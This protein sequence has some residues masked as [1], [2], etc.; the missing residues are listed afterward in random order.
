MGNPLSRC[1]SRTWSSLPLP[2]P[3]PLPPQSPLWMIYLDCRQHWPWREVEKPW[4]PCQSPPFTPHTQASHLLWRSWVTHPV[5]TVHRSL[6]SCLLQAQ[7]VSF[8]T[9]HSPGAE[10]GELLSRGAVGALLLAAGPESRIPGGISGGLF[11]ADFPPLPGTL[12][13]RVM[14]CVGFIG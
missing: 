9:Q 13:V 2:P 4:E 6:S 7:Q 14:C 1:K 3:T 5:C 8:L 11:S 12:F 10:A